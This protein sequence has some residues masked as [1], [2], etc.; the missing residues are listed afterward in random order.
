MKDSVLNFQVRKCAIAAKLVS[1]SLT[2]TSPKYDRRV[3]LAGTKLVDDDG[4]IYQASNSYQLLNLERDQSA[5][6]KLE[7]AVTKNISLPATVELNGLLDSERF[8]HNF[9]VK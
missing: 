3:T 1:C 4:D 8:S 5:T 9:K 2:V 6:F 7:F